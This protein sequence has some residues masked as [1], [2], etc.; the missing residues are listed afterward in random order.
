MKIIHII[1]SL[2]KGEQKEIFIVY[3][4]FK[5]NKYKNNINIIIITLINNGNYEL[6]LKN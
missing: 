5:K 4:D 3:V 6:E 1:N 2:K